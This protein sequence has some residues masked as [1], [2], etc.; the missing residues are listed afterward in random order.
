[1]E[2]R[3]GIRNDQANVLIVRKH[4]WRD[5]TKKPEKSSNDACFFST[6]TESVNGH[7]T[8][9]E[10]TSR[11]GPEGVLSTGKPPKSDSRQLSRGSAGE[12]FGERGRN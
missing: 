6:K 7:F 8:T 4:I 9:G 1:V 3:P 2:S 10:K 11:G 12:F 5:G